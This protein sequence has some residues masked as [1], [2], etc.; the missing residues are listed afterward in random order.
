M[1]SLAQVCVLSADLRVMRGEFGIDERAEQRNN[2]A[3][4]PRAENERG[5]VNLLRDDVRIDEDART[6]DA[7]HHNHRRIEQP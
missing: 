7:A 3:C 1:K 2:A 5:R 6:D 4:K